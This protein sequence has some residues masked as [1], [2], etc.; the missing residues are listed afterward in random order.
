MA[1][2]FGSGWEKEE[3]SSELP[4]LKVGSNENSGVPN[5][6]PPL[7]YLQLFHLFSR[8]R[9]LVSSTIQVTLLYGAHRHPQI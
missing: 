4:C 2:K 7:K 1:K 3:I 8:H 5:V 6:E 9:G